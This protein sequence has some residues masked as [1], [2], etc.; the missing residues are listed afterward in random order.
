MYKKQKDF[1]PQAYPFCLMPCAFPKFILTLMPYALCLLLLTSFSS[2][3]ST[4]TPKQYMD[5]FEAHRAEFTKTIEHNGVKAIVA[6]LPT[7]YYVARDMASDGTLKLDSTIKRYENS[8]FF[9]FTIIGDKYKNGSVLLEQQGI[10]NFK[11]N[12]ELN[13]FE[14]GQD[15]FLFSG[16][17]TIRTSGYNYDRNWGMGS[18]DAFLIAFA[19]KSLKYKMETYHLIIREMTS[20]LGTVDIAVKDLIIKNKRLKG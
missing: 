2:C 19:K 5:Y 8:L 10:D 9:V 12:V 3:N 1:A 7:E 17:D 13:T 14:R 15:I 16:S 4:F 18:G 11:E 20:E 6:Y